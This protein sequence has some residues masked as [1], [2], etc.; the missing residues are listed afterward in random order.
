MPSI[1]DII[2]REL[3]PFDTVQTGNFW[4]STEDA[5]FLVES[6]HQNEVDEIAEILDLVAI[7]HRSYSVLL[8]GDSGCGKSYFLGRLKRQFNDKAFF[9]YIGPWAD[10]DHIWR[11]VL[12]YTVDSLIQT[13]EGQQESQLLLWLKSLSAFTRQNRSIWELL[14]SDRQKFI[15]HLKSNYEREGIY[16]ADVF[17][18]IL[19]AL[20]QQEL[21]SQAYEWLRGDQID[22]ESMQALGIRRCIDSEDD[23]KNILANFGKISTSTYPIVLCFDNIVDLTPDFKPNVQPILNINTTIHNENLKNFLVIISIMK[24]TWQR[25]AN[26]ISQSD[27][28]R[29]DREVTL[30]S[31]NLEQ[32]ESLWAYRL[33]PLHAKATPRPDSR[34]Y[35]LTRQLLEVNY[36]GAKALPRDV[37]KLGRK[38]YQ[39]YKKFL[40]EAKISLSSKDSSD[41]SKKPAIQVEVESKTP[42]PSRDERI[43]A[44]FNL[45]WQQEYK[46]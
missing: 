35:P 24:D 22:E 1:D 18:R 45:L 26:N 2:K 12:R 27:K 9:A 4:T 33:R 10:N 7:T 38:K 40:N 13:P 39:E 16:N 8:I 23:A 14:L 36:P 21:Y 32:A 34:I 5:S 6:I 17:F 37:L 19:Y 44:E 42:P 20:T 43:K 29:I 46:K 15:N 31:I 28:A 41:D 11:H 3:N 30:E 25:A